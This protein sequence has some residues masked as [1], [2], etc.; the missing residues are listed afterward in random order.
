MTLITCYDLCH[1]IQSYNKHSF[2]KFRC[3]RIYLILTVDEICL[4]V[5][6]LS[7]FISINYP[8]CYL[9]GLLTLLLHCYSF[10]HLFHTVVHIT[11]S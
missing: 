7:A 9:S 10:L 5:M 11:A 4:S 1:L 3:S 8:F 6:L 2:L